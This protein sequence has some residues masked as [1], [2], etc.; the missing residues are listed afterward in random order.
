MNDCIEILILISP[1]SCTSYPVPSCLV[2]SRPVP[3]QARKSGIIGSIFAF[4]L[5]VTLVGFLHLAIRLFFRVSLSV[6]S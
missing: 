5:L 2:P 3:S 6:A 1:P 4:F